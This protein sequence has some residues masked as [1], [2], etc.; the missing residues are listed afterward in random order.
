MPSSEA[1][2]AVSTTVLY[3]Q[4]EVTAAVAPVF[5]VVTVDRDRKD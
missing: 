3:T 2:S 4:A 5:P 1:V